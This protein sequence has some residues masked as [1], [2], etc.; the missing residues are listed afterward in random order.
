VRRPELHRFFGEGGHEA[1]EPGFGLGG[2][3][4]GQCGSGLL[5]IVLYLSDRSSGVESISCYG[6]VVG[7]RQSLATVRAIRFN[8]D[9]NDRHH[10]RP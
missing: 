2:H 8:G 4:Q 1:V 6:S 9:I 5:R 3:F 10:V 7:S